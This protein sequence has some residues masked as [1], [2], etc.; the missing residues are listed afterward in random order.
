MVRTRWMVVAALFPLVF[1]A[2]CATC[3]SGGCGSKSGCSA[4]TCE[5]KAADMVAADPDTETMEMI[6]GKIFKTDEEWRAE[7]T[8]EQYRVTREKGTE[9]A[10]SGCYWDNKEPGLY[11]CV[12]CGLPLFRSGAKFESGSGWPSFLTPYHTSHIEEESDTSHGMRRTE[13]H[14]A[15]CGAHLGHVFPD[16]PAPT[17]L[18]YC[19]NSASLRFEPEEENE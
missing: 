9:P 11:R 7:L 19:I 2:G 13:V 14:C 5:T 6:D 16:G 8:P 18:R 17:G 10:F 1:L 15:R 12:A 3:G 4:S